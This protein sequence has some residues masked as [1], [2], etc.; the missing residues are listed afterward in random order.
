MVTPRGFAAA[1][2]PAWI[3]SRSPA[4]V[5][6]QLQRGRLVASV[7]PQV[8]QPLQPRLQLSDDAAQLAGLGLG[9]V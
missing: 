5:A 3:G 4:V 7:A 6:A 2:G 1:T 9:N 8:L